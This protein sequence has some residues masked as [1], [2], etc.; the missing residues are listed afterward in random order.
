MRLFSD[1]GAELDAEFRLVAAEGGCDLIFHSQGGASAGRAPQNPDY[2]EA[3]ETLLVRLKELGVTLGDA[4]VDSTQTMNLPLDDRRISILPDV[5]PLA[6]A[7]ISDLDDLRRRIRRSVSQIGQ[8]RLAKGGNGNKR[9]RLRLL[10][11][12]EL[13]R[14]DI[15]EGLVG[16]RGV[17]RPSRYDP[18][19]A[20][21]IAA[22][23]DSFELSWQ[24]ISELVGGLGVAAR[25]AQFWATVKRRDA[26]RPQQRAWR[27]AGFRASLDRGRMMVGFLRQ[28]PGEP[29]T[30]RARLPARDP[31]ATFWTL[32][33]DPKTWAIDRFLASGEVRGSWSVPP[34]HAGRFA[35]GQLALMRVGVDRRSAR[36]REGRP[37]LEAG[38]Y[39]ICL[40]ESTA[41]PHDGQGDPYRSDGEARAATWPVI[42]IRYLRRYL[43]R[44]LRLGEECLPH[45]LIKVPPAATFPI[46]A[47]A[48]RLVLDR[49]GENEE[50][51]LAGFGDER[52]SDP[53]A[54]RAAWLQFRDAPPAVKER[55]SRYVERGPN[56]NLVKK[57]NGYRC[58]ICDGLG[59]DW[60]S[61]AK[62]DGTP[63]IEAHHVVQVSTLEADVLGPQ[64]ILTVCPNH[65]RQ[66][67]YGG[68]TQ[69]DVGDAFEFTFPGEVT[70]LVRKYDGR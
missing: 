10:I 19:Y 63:Y 4:V 3:L 46:S 37:P 36:V 22:P 39:A 67:H 48:F 28:H 12:P 11:P 32:V 66:L 62:T 25:E 43:D 64:N 38:I 24:E 9:L 59:L 27:D 58:Q 50:H 7:K 16:R 26:S 53:A 1:A 15:A 31:E 21:L 6:L 47:E 20:R 45:A 8:T 41:A 54:L 17:R 30:R 55:L 44:P 52:W 61:F 29:T 5:F 51:L 35:P 68:V 18:L 65:H 49:L 40:I 14:D 13:T 60:T 69:R 34:T 70:V 23:E 56:G 33:C 42:R 2:V 57:A